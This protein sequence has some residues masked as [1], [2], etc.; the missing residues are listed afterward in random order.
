LQPKSKKQKK[1][2]KQDWVMTNPGFTNSVKFLFGST[3]VELHQQIVAFR[4]LVDPLIISQSL[5]DNS[6]L[7]LNH[8]QTCL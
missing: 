3:G 8:I 6:G 7:T 1:N 2:N 5:L 4:A